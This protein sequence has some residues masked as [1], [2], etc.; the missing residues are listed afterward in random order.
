MT[1]DVDI[2]SLV[3]AK[4]REEASEAA[5]DLLD[6]VRDEG[7]TLLDDAYPIIIALLAVLSSGGGA[8]PAEVLS[9]LG[10]AANALSSSLKSAG[11]RNSPAG[12]TGFSELEARTVAALR[13]ADG[14]AWRY[15][16]SDDPEVRVMAV[17]LVVA[18]ATQCSP[19][20]ESLVGLYRAEP[21]LLARACIA[22]AVT[23]LAVDSSELGAAAVRWCDDLLGQAEPL[24]QF[25]VAREL[26]RADDPVVRE[27]AE[28]VVQE[29]A[30][31]ASMVWPSE[32]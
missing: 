24:V 12:D 4:S 11:S 18:T 14:L 3:D 13:N 30:D 21:N 20:F 1:E 10:G 22:A 7:D 27:K 5:L 9:V 28:A 8:W 6:Q 15:V 29:N 25:R 19:L 31:L 17:N 32:V 23:K 26:K 16:G 2:S